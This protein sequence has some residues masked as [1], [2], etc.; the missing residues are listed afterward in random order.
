M[1]CCKMLFLPQI[2]SLFKSLKLHNTVQSFIQIILFSF[3]TTLFLT[4]HFPTI[5][6]IVLFNV[7]AQTAIYLLHIF[8]PLWIYVLLKR[9]THFSISPFSVTES[10]DKP[11][12]IQRCRLCHANNFYRFNFTGFAMIIWS[13]SA[14]FFIWIFAFIHY[15]LSQRLWMSP[16]LSLACTIDFMILMEAIIY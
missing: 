14:I 12:E 13:L 7:N 9:V 10:C 15:L 8:S 2:F 5:H 11:K 3:H 6:R 16:I 1:S 4:S